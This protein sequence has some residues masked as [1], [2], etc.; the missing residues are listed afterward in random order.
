MIV[1]ILTDFD[2]FGLWLALSPVASYWQSQ[3]L[4][5][6]LREIRPTLVGYVCRFCL[7]GFVNFIICFSIYKL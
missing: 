6:R 5:G 2:I 1:E 3:R 4:A 7:T